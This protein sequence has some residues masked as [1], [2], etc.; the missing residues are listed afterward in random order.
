MAGPL[1]LVG[2]DEFRPGNE[3]QDQVLRDAAKA[4]PA[5]IIATAAGKGAAQAVATA[6]HW[7]NG[8]GLSVEE[9][10]VRTAGDARSE[11]VV[12]QA[13]TAGFIYLAGGDP[14]HVA[15]T[16]RSS[17]VWAAVH[18][19]WQGGAALAGSSAGAMALCEWTLVRRDFPGHTARRPMPA[20]GLLRG[21]AVLPHFDSFGERWIPSA[22]EALGEALLIGVDERTAAVWQEGLW[23]AMGPGLVTVIRGAQRSSFSSGERIEGI[24]EPE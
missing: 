14:G 9:L 13:R 24:P 15:T 19:A 3:A 7:F 4:R 1:A 2:G 22:Q 23:S 12:A 5:F 10:V 8:L 17:A 21:C 16:L 20:L 18:E 6:Q 11:A